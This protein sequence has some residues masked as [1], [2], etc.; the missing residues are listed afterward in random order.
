MHSRDSRA[1]PSGKV[2]VLMVFESLII[3]LTVIRSII[4]MLL[5]FRKVS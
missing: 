5:G 2:K 1:K 4:C 3:V